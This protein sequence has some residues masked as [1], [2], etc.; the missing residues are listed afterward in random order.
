[1]PTEDSRNY[2]SQPSEEIDV[3]TVSYETGDAGI[4]RTSSAPAFGGLPFDRV[5]RRCRVT[6]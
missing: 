1:M 6:A 3:F 5:D 2:V 4:R